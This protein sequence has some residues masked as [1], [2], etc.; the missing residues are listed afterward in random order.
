MLY[1]QWKTSELKKP[2]IY[3]AFTCS[4]NRWRALVDDFRTLH[5][6]KLRNLAANWNWALSMAA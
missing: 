4:K 5:Y 2:Q 3:G 6:E 1:I